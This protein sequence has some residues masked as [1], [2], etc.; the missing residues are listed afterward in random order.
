MKRSLG[1]RPLR[2]EKVLR[3]LHRLVDPK[4]TKSVPEAGGEGRTSARTTAGSS[5][6]STSASPSRPA[7]A[8]PYKAGPTG[9]S[10]KV[11]HSS[12]SITGPE[13]HAWQAIWSAPTAASKASPPPIKSI[14]FGRAL[15]NR[16]G[17]PSVSCAT[18]SNGAKTIARGVTHRSYQAA[19]PTQTNPEDPTD[20]SHA[21][22]SP[23][24]VPARPSTPAPT[25]TTPPALAD[26]V[27]KA[28]RAGTPAQHPTSTVR[29][30]SY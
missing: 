8:V 30:G 18:N 10:A 16:T 14:I 9:W 3:Q 26:G 7:R 15:R 1:A 28:P 4:N 21:T 22:F 24:T 23:A 5:R 27:I 19:A 11:R 20:A 12:G 6:R 25:T 13:A 2:R 17:L 29:K